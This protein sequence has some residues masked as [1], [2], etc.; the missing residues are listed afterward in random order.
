M[1]FETDD[2]AMQGEM[3]ATY[4]LAEVDGGTELLAAHEK[5]PAGVSLADNET[6]WRMSL[7][8]LAALVEAGW[9]GRG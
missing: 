3:T 1:A 7:G 2:P 8:K 4:T 6:G 9:T 5:V